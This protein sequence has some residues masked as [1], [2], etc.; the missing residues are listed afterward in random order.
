MMMK[1]GKVHKRT[2]K[3]VF[4]V[5]VWI[6]AVC[7]LLTSKSTFPRVEEQLTTASDDDS[8]DNGG[9]TG[10]RLMIGEDSR[11]DV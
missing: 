4:G 3:S 2:Q 1:I 10:Q 11:N 5:I 9:V 6:N 7:W 8:N